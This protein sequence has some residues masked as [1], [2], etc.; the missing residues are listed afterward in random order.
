MPEN[1]AKG[2]FCMQYY[3]NPAG[4]RFRSK[5]E[6]MR[7]LESAAQQSKGVTREEAVASA[8]A[9]AEQLDMRLPLTLDNSVTI[10][11]CTE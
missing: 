7:H 8:K 3:F 4:Q 10:V 6:I 2:G 11:R 9:T 5:Q 1:V